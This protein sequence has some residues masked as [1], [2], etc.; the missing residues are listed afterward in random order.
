MLKRDFTKSNKE[1]FKN[2]KNF[3]IAIGVFLLVGIL[4][5]AIFG[6]N[7]NFEIKG[8]NEFSITVNEKIAEEYTEDRDGIGSIINSFNGKFDNMQIYGEGD[9]TKF[10]VRYLNDLSE[11]EIFK[12]NNLVAQKL[13]VEVENISE[14][15]NVSS[16]VNSTD[17]VYTICSI[18]ILM[19]VVSIFAY[20][21]YN[22]ASALAVIL[23]NI[24]GT[25]AMLSFASILRLVVGLNFFAMLVILNVLIDYFAISIFESMHKSS[26]LMSRDFGTAIKTAVKNSRFRMIAITFAIL[27]IGI[28]FVLFAPSAFKYVTLNLMFMA[29]VLI[30]CGLYVIPFIWS[31]AI[32][33]CKQ[34]EYKVK[35]TIDEKQKHK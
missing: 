26:W 34:R 2:N 25:L 28:V 17:Y 12:V 11:T 15:V 21:R 9:D 22:G 3:L 24:L 4:V 20:A 16:K 7:G 33:H 30:A 27:L 31:A 8:Y 6:M 13:G 18:L 5:F 14:H 23:A 32:T 35:S 29:V 19:A 1:Y 10:V